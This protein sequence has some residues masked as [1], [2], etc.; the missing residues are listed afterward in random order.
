MEDVVNKVLES[1]RGI[2]ET[3]WHHQSFVESESDDEGC[4][5]FMSF[6]YPDSVENDDD[7]QF[8]EDFDF[9]QSI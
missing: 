4:L 3:E 5:P 7:V 9:V 8:D 2:V 6:S 1:V